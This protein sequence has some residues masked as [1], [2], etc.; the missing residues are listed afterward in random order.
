MQRSKNSNYDKTA[1]NAVRST[2][3]VVIDRRRHL[4]NQLKLRLTQSGK[5]VAHT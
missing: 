5:K 1:R 3:L 4:T 2:A